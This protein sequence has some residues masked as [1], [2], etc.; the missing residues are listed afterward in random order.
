MP[1][2]EKS[3]LAINEDTQKDKYLTFAV[4]DEM[5]GIDIKAVIEIIGIQPITSVPETPEYLR[6]IINLRGKIIP[7]VDMR[8]RFQKEFLPYHDRTCVIVVDMIDVMVGIIVDSVAEVLTIPE[9]SVV[10]PPKLKA[11]QNKCIRG[12]GK[13]GENGEK[14]TLLLDW[15]KLFSDEDAEMM[16]DMSVDN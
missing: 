15:Q 9:D 5:Y 13:S 16:A 14:A 2:E 11:A 3:M 12:I 4:G 7:I 6:G 10:L 8:L 1:D